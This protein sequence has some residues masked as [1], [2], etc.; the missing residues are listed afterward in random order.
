M[1]AVR[2]IESVKIHLVVVDTELEK[3]KGWPTR[4]KCN[5]KQID[6]DICNILLVVV[7]EGRAD[8][9]L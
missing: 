3:G 2:Q 9:H 5:M 6:R 4:Q 7:A 8:S 1:F